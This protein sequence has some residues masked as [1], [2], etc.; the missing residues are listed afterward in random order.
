MSKKKLFGFLCCLV[1]GLML[2]AF[3]LAEE[4]ISVEDR[5]L[6]LTEDVSVHYPVIMGMADEELQETVNE[7]ILTELHI[8]EYLSRAAQLLSGG[9]LK[10]E[11]N[12]G[13]LEDV[14]SCSAFAE[15]ALETLR[16]TCLWT[17]ASLD[18]RTG[19]EITLAHLFTDVEAARERIEA[20]LDE[21]VAPELSPLLSAGALT[22]LPELFRLEKTGLRLL[23]PV[24]Q[25]STLRDRAGE[26][27]IPW[28]ALREVLN[29]EEDSVLSRIGVPEMITLS[30]QS[31]KK[32]LALAE[33]GR[34]PGIPASMGDSMQSLTD[35][36]GMLTDPDGFE[37]GRLFS[38]EEG[39]FQGVFLLTDD[40]SRD[41][42]NSRVQGIRMDR[43]C[44]YGLC[45]GETLRQAWL[46]ALGEPD[47]TA[48]ISLEKAE[49]N[50]LDPGRCDYYTC[51]AYQLRL[52]S[53]DTETLISLVLTE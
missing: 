32:L 5:G 25:L 4:K 51:G 52:Y 43:G 7:Q 6:E 42:E 35:Q 47:H 27:R 26:V 39:S 10:V 18:L 1:A 21:T 34:L 31:G 28:S 15:G 49:A 19:E 41:W 3:C 11:W 14:F 33:E 9:R 46:E 17:A 45:V 37:N 53:D 23:Y 50:R 8:R 29:L 16:E 38:L 48:E 40:L 30:A 36:Y 13:I 24:S 44:A 22:P 2:A 20:W 12:G